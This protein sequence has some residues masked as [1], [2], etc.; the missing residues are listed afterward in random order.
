MA[1]YD[2]DGNIF[3]DCFKTYDNMYSKTG[4]ILLKRFDYLGEI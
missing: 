3:I 2:R 4:I 1:I